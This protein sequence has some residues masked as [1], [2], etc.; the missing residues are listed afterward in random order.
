PG[1][2]CVPPGRKCTVVWIYILSAP[3]PRCAPS[4]K[5]E[6]LS[7]ARFE[8]APE[9]ARVLRVGYGAA[10]LA[11]ASVV[12]TL[13]Q[14][15]GITHPRFDLPSFPRV[16][17]AQ[18]RPLAVIRPVTL[19]REWLHQSRS[20]DPRYVAQAAR[21]LRRHFYVVSIAD[22]EDGQEWLAGPAPEAD[23]QLHH[24]ELNV[25][26][27]LALTEQAAV[28]VGGVG[29]IVP[30]AI[31]YGTPLY[32]IQGGCGAHNAP[33][34]ITDRAMDLR[35]VGW[36]LPDRFCMCGEMT[37]HCDKHISHFERN[38]KRWLYENVL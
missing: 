16:L 24:G 19:R 9:G 26:Q 11:R 12:E 25:M 23:L 3:E 36:A 17:P 18:T 22:L 4:A 35:R 6:R 31:C 2:T 21:I 33:H 37:H 8:P 14:Q 10:S 5:N 13:R 38:F 28:V 27:L 29:W 15:F 32:V 1:R 7:P 30:A 20:P 34:I